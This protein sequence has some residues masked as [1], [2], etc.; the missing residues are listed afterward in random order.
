MCRCTITST[1]DIKTIIDTHI[2]ETNIETHIV[3]ANRGYSN[4]IQSN[5]EASSSSHIQS[6]DEA[7]IIE[8][9]INPYILDSSDK[10][11][12]FIRNKP[13]RSDENL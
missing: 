3:D 6:N 13:M 8:T 7:Y 11:Y 9:N 12:V 1:R 5:N 10:S 4:H 2:V